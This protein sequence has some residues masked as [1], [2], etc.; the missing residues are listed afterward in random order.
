MTPGSESIAN[1]RIVYLGPNGKGLTQQTTG[2]DCWSVPLSG[3]TPTALTHAALAMSCAASR[4]GLVWSQHIEDHPVQTPAVGLGD[5]PHT[6]WMRPWGGVP[7]LLQR[8]AYIQDYSPIAGDGWA[9]WV[10]HLRRVV[11]AGGPLV[12]VPGR[13]LQAT[14]GAGAADMVATLSSGHGRTAIQVFRVGVA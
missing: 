12:T 8:Q 3:G 7:Q 6:L 11:S 2:G 5:D 10:P 9:S 4:S 1:G 13:S 14:F